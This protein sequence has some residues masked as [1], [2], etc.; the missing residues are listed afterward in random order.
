[1]AVLAQV[2]A[3]AVAAVVVALD[4]MLPQTLVV[5]EEQAS[6]VPSRVQV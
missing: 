2:P 3:L 6:Q 5:L 1:M 4:Q